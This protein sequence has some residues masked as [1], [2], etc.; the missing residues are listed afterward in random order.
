MSGPDLG[1]GFLFQLSFDDEE[2]SVAFTYHAQDGG[3]DAGGPAAGPPD[4]LGYTHPGTPCMFGGPRCWERRFFLGEKELVP[5][6]A[7]YQRTRFAMGALLAHQYEGTPVPWEAG[8]EEFLRVGDPA[9]RAAKIPY[10]V[11][12][13]GASWLRAQRDP[14]SH[15]SVELSPGGADVLG[16]ALD[17]YL[18]EPVGPRGPEEGYGGRAFLGTFKTGLRVDF[19]EPPAG[20][21]R[22]DWRVVEIP[23]AGFGVPVA[24]SSGKGDG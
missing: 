17:R 21:G 7:A 12:G 4:F 6:R 9:L 23:W 5:V 3:V 20:A 13:G 18:I 2:G 24:V 11:I 1:A 8:F 15:L 10:R 19:H 14:P 16:G 22:I